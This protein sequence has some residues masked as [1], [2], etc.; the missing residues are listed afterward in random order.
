MLDASSHLAFTSDGCALVPAGVADG[1]GVAAVP[2]AWPA[3]A[4]GAGTAA[5]CG[6]GHSAWASATD[7]RI[8]GC[9]GADW[10]CGVGWLCGG[11]AS[12]VVV[13]GAVAA[14]GCALVVA[15]LAALFLASP[16]YQHFFLLR[17]RW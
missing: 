6:E 10:L 2:P 7:L 12:A 14:G 13:S 8:A 3:S 16:R 9:C 15:V 5:T 17:S 11:V 1:S 4:L